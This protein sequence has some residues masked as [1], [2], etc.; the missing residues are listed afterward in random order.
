MS[1]DATGAHRVVDIVTVARGKPVRGGARRG[2]PLDA[3]EPPLREA[4]V[5]TGNGTVSRVEV[6]L[7]TDHPDPALRGVAAVLLVRVRRADAPPPPELAPPALSPEAMRAVDALADRLGVVITPGDVDAEIEA[8]WRRLEEPTLVELKLDPAL[9]R[10][11]LSLWLTDPAMRAEIEE[12]LRRSLALLRSAPKQLEAAR[13]E[14]FLHELAA[15]AHVSLTE[16]KGALKVDR[17]L[18]AAAERL[19]LERA[20]LEQL[21]VT[22]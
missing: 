9:R 7:A 8:R 11:A 13:V 12:R 20:A 16:L 5:K 14:L 22:R 21:G 15:A 19:L 6:T 4:L 3:L 10:E 1:K 18:A 2:L 17:G